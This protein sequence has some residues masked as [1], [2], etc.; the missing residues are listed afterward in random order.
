M[1]V[2][3]CA[4]VFAAGFC[5]GFGFDALIRV[6]PAAAV[7][8]VFLARYF[9]VAVL[10][11][12]AR[13]LAGLRFNV[14]RD[15]TNAPAHHALAMELYAKGEI[16]EALQAFIN[17][18]DLDPSLSISR[19]KATLGAILKKRARSW[20][21]REAARHLMRLARIDHLFE[22]SRRQGA[23]LPED[24]KRTMES[25]RAELSGLEVMRAELSSFVSGS[26]YYEDRVLIEREMRQLREKL[27]HL[28]DIMRHGEED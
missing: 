26:E 6:S 1:K 7:G 27:T 3:A 25:L 24:C 10:A 15:P 23:E 22:R 12:R 20:R 4:G 21:E 13:R 8:C 17:S 11:L 16:H 18:V 5:G 28:E 19:S 9:Y 2:L 14:E